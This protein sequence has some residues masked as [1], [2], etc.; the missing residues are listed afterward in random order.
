M[1][2][3]IYGAGAIGGVVG[4]HL[5]RAGYEVVLIARPAQATAINEHGLRLVTPAGTHVLP[6]SA[7]TSPN[8]IDFGKDDVIFLSMK[9]Q[10][11]EE[12]LH[13]LQAVIKDIP[14]FCLQNGVR[15]EEIAA[16][17]F[18]RVYGAMLRCSATY[19]TPGEVISRLDPPG[20]IVIGRYPDGTDELV[21]D[22]AAKLRTS[23]F[24]VMSSPEVM[25]HKWGKLI[26]NIANAVEAICNISRQEA[27][28]IVRAAQREL[29][30]LLAR[31]SIRLVSLEESI[32]EMRKEW[33]E[34]AM[35]PRGRLNIEARSSTWQSLA[36]GQGTV[37]SEY[38]NGE[39]VRL[40]RKLGLRAP[41]NEKLQGITQEMAANHEPPGKYTLAQLS[42]LLELDRA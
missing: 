14:I 42:T 16:R 9:G 6:L 10:N 5:S 11:T 23:G 39:V 26:G 28:T 41:I 15:N 27:D 34:S 21:E 31:A 13:D 30:E 3:I 17:Y 7:V 22:L 25:A 38:L 24:L 29:Q 36:R 2:I 37:E 19:L 18:P 4:G 33:P 12:A 32:E 1:K 35:P 20:Y 40:A 8:Q